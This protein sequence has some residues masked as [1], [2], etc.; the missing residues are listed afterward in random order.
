MYSTIPPIFLLSA[1]KNV[2][3][4]EPLLSLFP[5]LSSLTPAFPVPACQEET[6]SSASSSPCTALQTFLLL[7]VPLHFGAALCSKSHPSSCC[8]RSISSLIPAQLSGRFGPSKLHL[9]L[10]SHSFALCPDPFPD[11]LQWHPWLS[12]SSPG[13]P[14][15]CTVVFLFCFFFCHYI[16][17]AFPIQS[18]TARF[19]N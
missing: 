8:R 11:I 15:K 14:W 7:C 10:L 4:T 5:M 16:C 1:N 12:N 9:F 13:M 17:S 3:R 19:Y 6:C 18:C 2:K